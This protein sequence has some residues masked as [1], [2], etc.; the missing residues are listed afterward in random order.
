MSGKVFEYV[1]EGSRKFVILTQKDGK[2]DKIEIAQ[3]LN[4][5]VIVWNFLWQKI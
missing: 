3:N 4:Y 5:N 1:I 2:M